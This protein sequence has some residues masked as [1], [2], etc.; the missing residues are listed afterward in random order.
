MPR[1]LI[2]VEIRP[3]LVPF[4][5]QEFQG[6]TANYNGKKVKAVKIS[7]RN[8]FGKLIRLLVEKCD[9]P[10]TSDKKYSIFLSISEQQLNTRYFGKI[11]RYVDGRNSFLQI[12]QE[13]VT[14]INEY[15]EGIFRSNCLFYLDGWS[16]KEG[17]QGLNIGILKF[18]DKYNLLEFGFDP[19]SV[20]RNY[21]RWK[22]D[23]NRLKFLTVQSSNRV[24][25]Y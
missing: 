6:I 7:T 22:A 16:E 24:H 3:H 11:Y 2:P 10:H 13:G 15:L 18:I 23:E 4:L 12:P 25:N 9:T 1:S 14:M 19:A 17:E 5:F 8:Y 21:Y 20:K